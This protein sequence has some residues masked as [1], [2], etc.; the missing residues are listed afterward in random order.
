[1]SWKPVLGVAALLATTGVGVGFFYPFHE[2]HP[3]LRLPGVV[4][5]QEIRLGS[6]IAGRVAEVLVE[7]GQLVQPGQELVRF[8]VPELQAQR[9]QQEARIQAAEAELSKWMNGSRP[10]EIRQM[11][12]DWESAE[13]DRKYALQDFARIERLF[14]QGSASRAEFDLARAARDRSIGHTA[15]A[16]AKLDLLQAGTRSEDIA[17]AR[18]RLEE[19]RGRLR[20]LEANLREAIVRAPGKAMIEVLSVRKGDLVPPNQP[21]LRVL[22]AEDLWIKIYVP[23]TELGKV[24]IGQKAK[25]SI[26]AYPGRF[27]EGEVYQIASES[28]FTPRNIQSIDER[29]HQVFAVRV[30]V[31]Q[32]EDPK[33]RIFRS[34]LAAEVELQLPGE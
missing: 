10:E 16:K 13:A 21:I 7:E 30:R 15:S 9:V 25:V 2:Y 1:M 22:R 34:G 6:K 28:E 29:R 31:Q 12:S 23:E 27:F 32:P 14:R 24:R 17:A 11:Q 8:E 4:E 20:E 3:T 19:H 33:A 18:A 5:T 26:D